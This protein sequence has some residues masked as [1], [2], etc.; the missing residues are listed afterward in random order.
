[1]FEIYQS[2][3][4]KQFYF[5]LKAKNSQIILASEGYK[6]KAVVSQKSITA[7]FMLLFGSNS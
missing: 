7:V 3:K 5:R 1:M 6:T 4:N 2:P